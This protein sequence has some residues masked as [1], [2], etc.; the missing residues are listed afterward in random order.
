MDGTVVAWFDTR[1]HANPW[2]SECMFDLFLVHYDDG[3]SEQCPLVKIE[4]G[5]GHFQQGKTHIPGF[6]E[7]PF[8]IP[9]GQLATAADVAGSRPRLVRPMRMKRRTIRTRT[10]K[11]KRKQKQ[12]LPA[13]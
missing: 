2:G 11:R 5:I 9:I 3:D 6:D 10:R 7:R 12:K 1:G 4:E 13:R 8:K